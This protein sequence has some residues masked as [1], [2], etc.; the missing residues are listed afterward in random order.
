MPTQPIALP[1]DGRQSET[2]REVVRGTR[3]LLRARNIATVTELV[4]ADG[5]RPLDTRP[6]TDG[7]AL[8]L[9]CSEAVLP[10]TTL[11]MPGGLPAPRPPDTPLT[12]IAS[13]GASPSRAPDAG[14][15]GQGRRVARG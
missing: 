8:P 10:P 14:G 12:V 13:G 5:R 2:A 9:P 3:R 4:L 11:T 7:L 15:G 1:E 6:R